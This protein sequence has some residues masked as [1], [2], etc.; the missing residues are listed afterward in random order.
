MLRGK[1][2]KNTLYFQYA[3]RLSRFLL[4]FATNNFYLQLITMVYTTE[5]LFWD[6]ISWTSVSLIALWTFL[7]GRAGKKT[8]HKQFCIFKSAV[9]RTK[10]Y[11]INVDLFYALCLHLERKKKRTNKKISRICFL[12]RTEH[13]DINNI[14]CDHCWI[15]SFLY[16]PQIVWSDSSLTFFLPLP[17]LFLPTSGPDL[18]T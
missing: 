6:D 3:F 7:G 12:K 15:S 5:Q 9:S 16:L 13:I 1:G 4:L 17:K 10:L 8:C 2:L 18:S 14:W 11:D